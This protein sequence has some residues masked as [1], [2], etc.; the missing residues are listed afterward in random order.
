MARKTA[1][2]TS[3]AADGIILNEVFLTLT[4]GRRPLKIRVF[5]ANIPNEFTLQLDILRAYGASLRRETLRLEEK[6]VSLWILGAGPSVP[7]W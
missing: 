7:A 1:E 3:H 6:E 4:L 2:P 5:V